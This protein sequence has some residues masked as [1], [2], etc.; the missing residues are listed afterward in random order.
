M[1][2]AWFRFRFRVKNILIDKFSVNW[3]LCTTMGLITIKF[4][5]RSLYPVVSKLYFFGGR[6]FVQLGPLSS[7]NYSITHAVI[8]QR[9]SKSPICNNIKI[10]DAWFSNT[11][12]SGNN[13]SRMNK[14]RWTPKCSRL[15]PG[16]AEVKA[17]GDHIACWRL[18]SYLYAWW[19][20]K[21]EPHACNTAVAY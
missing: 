10:H 11:F 4:G 14:K 7:S 9:F 21:H 8:E 3:K 15:A 18:I 13:K 17:H 19:S 20:V 6:T 1:W 12:T 2:F 5:R 16:Q